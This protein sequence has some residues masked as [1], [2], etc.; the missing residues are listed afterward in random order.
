MYICS[1]H[2]YKQFKQRTTISSR[3]VSNTVVSDEKIEKNRQLLCLKFEIFSAQAP[4]S[5]TIWL[6]FLN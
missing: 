2:N 1:V 5:G 6:I 3:F 4:F